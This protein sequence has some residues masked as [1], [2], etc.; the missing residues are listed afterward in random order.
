MNNHNLTPGQI[1]RWIQA[2]LPNLKHSG[3]EWRGPC[4]MHNG[5]RDNFSFNVEKG[6]GNCHSKCKDGFSISAIE[7]KLTGCD[8]KDALKQIRALI[9]D[10]TSNGDGTRKPTAK[11]G[12]VVAVYKYTDEQGNLLYE[13]RRHEPKDFSQRRP[14]GKGGWIYNLKDVRRVLY[15]LPK[16]LSAPPDEPV[17][18]VEGEKDVHS[19]EGLGF[20]ATSA[21]MGARKWREE[22]SEVLTGRQVV[23]LPDNDEDGRAHASQVRA[24]L[25]GKACSVLMVDLPGL[26]E[27]GD[28][29]DWIKSG[30]DRDALLRL[31]EEARRQAEASTST[32]DQ[33]KQDQTPD[34]PKGFKLTEEGLFRVTE[35][36]E[37]W[38]CAPL[39][40]V[41]LTRDAKNDDWGK[42]L[43][44]KDHDGHEHTVILSLSL[45]FGERSEWKKLL[46]S[47]GL[48]IN[49]MKE[50]LGALGE[51]L[52]KSNPRA[53]ARKVDVIGW[54]DRGL[55]FITPGWTIP[56]EMPERILLDTRTESSHYFR[57]AGTLEDWR[58]AI[59]EPCRGNP[60][61][62]FALCCGFAPPL[63][64]FKHGLGGGFHFA[65][66]STTGKSTA[67]R[68]AGSVWGG[69]GKS[70][71]GHSW[72]MTKNGAEALGISHNHCLLLLDEL[73]E[74]RDKEKAGDLAYFFAHGEA[75][76]RMTKELGRRNLPSFD[77]LFLS[78]GEFGFLDLVRKYS[79][80]T[81]TGQEVRI[82]EIPADRGKWGIFDRLN[83]E[84]EPGKFA[85]AL[86]ERALSC[87]GT[88]APSFIGQILKVG[89][90]E[91]KARLVELMEAF[92]AAYTKP[93]THPEVLR[94]LQRFAF[95]A[96]A[97]ELAT[98]WRILPWETG[99]AAA[100]TGHCFELWLK[101]RGTSGSRQH[102]EALTHIREYIGRYRDSRFVRHTA[103]NR[104]DPNR[105]YQQIDGYI[106]E[107]G[108]G[109]IEV[110]FK[111][112]I[113]KEVCGPYSHELIIA[114][115]EGTDVLL[116]DGKHRT[117]KRQL[118]DM[119]KGDRDRCVVLRFARLYRTD[120]DV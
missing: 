72:N 52:T 79:G 116:K 113:P 59:G 2:R 96:T 102:M 108:D 93:N 9:G 82:C 97:G 115:L 106:S 24:S 71:F 104:T 28:V 103:G 70:G 61:L 51:F 88:A 65:S 68:V 62:Q 119:P 105:T 117:V 12:P 37:L 98:K 39:R 26:P 109:P 100:A 73:A 74:L 67:L 91:V 89:E 53:R 20:T 29:S 85:Q 27:K 17:F 55:I 43:A 56:A 44:F 107:A 76:T 48:N 3:E 33:A 18:I 6:V 1:E 99:E 4:P 47:A 42:E 80:R 114:A 10:T 46:V 54:H 31:I 15:R 40:V 112:R 118:P 60:A 49:P 5:K 94:I 64:P 120:E 13:S 86:T 57:Q 75:T 38:L 45:L 22:Y 110:Q 19:L 8:P 77:L 34:I 32:P 101:K 84:S 111:D 66:D 63:L 7:A 41:S 14:D 90:A 92:T 35:E 25:L 30:G 36:R 23:I 78:S 11:R 58:R 81:Y 50:A 95:V 83:G 69:G 21:P 87:Y 16:L